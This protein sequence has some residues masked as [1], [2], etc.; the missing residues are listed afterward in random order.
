[1]KGLIMKKPLGGLRKMG[2]L[3]GLGGALGG[4]KKLFKKPET[5]DVGDAKKA[6]QA[7]DNQ[8]TKEK[9]EEATQD[10]KKKTPAKS[11][12]PAAKKAE[13]KAEAKETKTREKKTKEEQPAMGGGSKVGQ[14]KTHACLEAKVPF[15]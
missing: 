5:K 9:T 13:A 2:G 3:G 4:P 12:P 10:S 11:T 14:H 1:M 8:E 7:S 6:T 15:T